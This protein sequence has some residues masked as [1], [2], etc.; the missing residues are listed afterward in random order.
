MARLRGPGARDGAG[1][2]EFA[3]GLSAGSGHR[4]ARAVATLAYELT[5]GAPSVAAV[6][7]AD[8]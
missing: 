1:R 4:A 6:K 8:L 2:S 3:P 7:G 5:L